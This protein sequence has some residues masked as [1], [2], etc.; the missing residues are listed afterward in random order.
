MNLADVERQEQPE[1][2]DVGDEEVVDERDELA[3]RQARDHRAEG[4]HRREH[5]HE[6]R[7]EQMLQVAHAARD[8]HLV[9]QRPQH[10]IASEQAEEIRERPQERAHFLRPRGNEAGEPAP[11]LASFRHVSPITHH[12]SRL[13]GFAAAI[14]S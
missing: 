13:Q 1:D 14:V 7:G 5:H 2:C 4:G 11:R 10:V 8:P 3:S 12:P 9:A 6:G